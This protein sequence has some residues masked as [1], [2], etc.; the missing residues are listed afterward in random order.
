MPATATKS[1]FERTGKLCRKIDVYA[2]TATGFGRY[3][4]S[5]NWHKTCRDACIS[6]AEDERNG[7]ALSDLFGRFDTRA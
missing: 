3:V 4:C 7:Y 5:T 1:H 6:V 2:K